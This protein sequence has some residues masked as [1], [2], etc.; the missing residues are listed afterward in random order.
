MAQ[1][2]GVSQCHMTLVE[3]LVGQTDAAW[4]VVAGLFRGVL[5]AVLA[6]CIGVD[7]VQ[8]GTKAL[9]I[10]GKHYATNVRILIGFYD[11]GRDSLS[12]SR[13]MAFWRSGRFRVISKRDRVVLPAI[14]R[15]WML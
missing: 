11:F 10:A 3:H 7:Q 12:I 14:A 6:A 4:A 13:L 5:A 2:I 9:A 8:T 15:S 1:I